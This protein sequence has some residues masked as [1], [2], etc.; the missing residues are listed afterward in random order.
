[1]DEQN[2]AIVEINKAE[3]ALDSAN[4]IHEMLQLRDTA[5]AYEVLANARGFKDVAQKAKIFQLKAERKAGDW[6]DKNV[7]LSLIHI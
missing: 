3:L 4:D 1:M 5:S 7:D 6:L 2:T